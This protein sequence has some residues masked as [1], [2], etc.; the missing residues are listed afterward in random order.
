MTRK[1]YAESVKLIKVETFSV[2]TTPSTPSTTTTW[3]LQVSLS[4]LPFA[5]QHSLALS[6]SPHSPERSSVRQMYTAVEA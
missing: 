4:S 2:A 6:F 3:K 1:K 5:V